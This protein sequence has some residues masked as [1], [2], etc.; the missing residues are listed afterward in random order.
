M[1]IGILTRNAMLYSTQRL[2][3]AAEARRHSVSI[4][5]TLRLSLR[6]ARFTRLELE[7][8]DHVYPAIDAAIP[9][10]GA[11]VT[12][13]GVAVVR[14]LEQRGILVTASSAGIVNS[15][16]KL[17]SV[18]IMTRAG[19]PFPPTAVVEGNIDEAVAAVGGYP[20]VFKL[21]QGT[22][23]HGVML[24][25]NAALARRIVALLRLSGQPLLVQAFVVEASGRDVRAIVVGDTCVAAMQRRAAAGEFRANLHLGGTAYGFSPVPE[26]I[27]QLAVAAT[28][29][30]DLAV[31]GVD[32]VTSRHGYQ[33]LE[34]NSS[35]GLEGIEA[36]TGVD[37]AAEM[38]GYLERRALA[39]RRRARRRRRKRRSQ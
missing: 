32:M 33:L 17:D 1:R 6:I 5:D 28:R 27:A 23:G 39:R 18:A 22:Q 21:N 36:A 20:V 4:I 2:W 10:I 38:I 8:S 26:E 13:H 9:R 12:H 7:V 19:L 37:V 15:R 25:T 3:E 24:A 11:S 16:N 14:R 30:H 35:P 31:A 29:A 34:V